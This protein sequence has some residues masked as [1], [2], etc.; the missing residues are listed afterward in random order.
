MPRHIPTLHHLCCEL[1]GSCVINLDNVLD[2]LHF[3][4]SHNI[5]ALQDRAE[6]FVRD[7]ASAVLKV[8]SQSDVALVLGRETADEITRAQAE[9][10]D[11]V[12]KNKL[13]G[14]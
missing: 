10:D 13:V 9:I 6:R 2:V 3:A 5:A 7:S 11:K 12:R 8:H 1:I 4:Q 14:T